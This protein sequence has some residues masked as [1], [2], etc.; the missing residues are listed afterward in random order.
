MQV[1][2]AQVEEVRAKAGGGPAALAL[3]MPEP[4][5]QVLT[6]FDNVDNKVGLAGGR[7]R[8]GWTFHFRREP[9]VGLFAWL[10]HH[11]VWE[12]PDGTLIDVTPFHEN[13]QHHPVTDAGAVLFQAEDSAEPAVGGRPCSLPMRFFPVGSDERV[14]H[15]VK[16][17]NRQEQ[18]APPL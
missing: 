4:W 16:E 7:R 5:A 1:T 3:H 14:A 2:M 8:L 10:T 13:G 18:K 12:H 9:G 15:Y 11:A 17:L 6:C